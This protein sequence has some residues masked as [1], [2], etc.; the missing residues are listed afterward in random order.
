MPLR[1]CPARRCRPRLRGGDRGVSRAG[2]F[3]RRA[4]GSIALLKFADHI[5]ANADELVAVEVKDTGKPTALTLSEE[6]GPMVDQV[7]FFA[8]A[9]RVLEGRIAG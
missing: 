9:A 2:A 5:E 6:I 7:R 8:G 4:S 1:R 3:R